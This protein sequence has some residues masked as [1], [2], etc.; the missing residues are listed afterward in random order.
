MFDFGYEMFVNQCEYYECTENGW[1]GPFT[2]DDDDCSNDLTRDILNTNNIKYYSIVYFKSYYYCNCS[3]CN[4]FNGI[5]M[6]KI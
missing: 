5:Y 3:F 6:C 2:L 4:S 1:I